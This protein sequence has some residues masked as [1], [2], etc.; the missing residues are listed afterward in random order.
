[1]AEIIQ[2][3]SQDLITQP[4]R[5]GMIVDTTS[6]DPDT[7]TDA[8]HDAGDTAIS[9]TDEGGAADGDIVR[10]GTGDTMEI[11]VVASATTGSITL[12]LGLRYDQPSGVPVVEIEKL[13][14]G[15]AGEG[16]ID[17]AVNE[18]VFEAGACTSAKTLIR[19]T[20]RITQAITWPAME[21]TTN[22]FAR[23]FGIPQSA[24]QGTGA[25]AT[26][27]RI[28]LESDAIKSVVNASLFVECSNEG[29]DIVEF[30]GWNLTPDLNKTWNVSR[31][32]TAELPFG[33]DVKTIVMLR[34]TPA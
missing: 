30:Q 27:W 26:P 6:P 32:S 17:F 7:T 31:N 4:D 2:F 8:D 18:E 29:G 20:T 23:A 34:H 15:H 19:K 13:N 5:V 11:G 22:L 12:D 14:M 28:A 1:M 24:I 16:G 9:V 33:G 10:I 25:P 3:S 21:W